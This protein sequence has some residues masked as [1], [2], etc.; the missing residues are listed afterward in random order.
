MHLLLCKLIRELN[1]ILMSCFYFL[2]LLLNR[3]FA[4][5]ELSRNQY[6][7]NDSP[8]NRQPI[9]GCRL[10]SAIRLI[11]LLPIPNPI[12]LGPNVQGPAELRKTSASVCLVCGPLVE[13]DEGNWQIFPV[14][15]H[16][17]WSARRIDSPVG[18]FIVPLPRLPIVVSYC[19][20]N[21]VNNRR[22]RHYAR[23]L[24]IIALAITRSD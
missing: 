5:K 18:H 8:I 12:S 1:R 4:V 23:S 24:D 2:L 9:N 21:V 13:T 20:L 15:V 17:A 11:H 16:P 6:R 14:L 19:R 22:C 7:L 10:L 3:V